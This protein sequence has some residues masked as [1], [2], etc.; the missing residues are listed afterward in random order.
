MIDHANTVPMNGIRWFG[1]NKGGDQG[2]AIGFQYP[3]DSP[4]KK[5]SSEFVG[6]RVRRLPELIV[7]RYGPAFAIESVFFKNSQQ[8]LPADNTRIVGGDH[9]SG[10]RIDR[11]LFRSVDIEKRLNVVRTYRVV[12]NR[13]NAYAQS[14]RSMMNVVCHR[15]ITVPF[16]V[17]S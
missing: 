15:L 13:W 12:S 9:A 1:L 11:D 10:Y 14:A 16:W 6:S 7:D 2:E 8:M 3:T 4:T 17:N 5:G